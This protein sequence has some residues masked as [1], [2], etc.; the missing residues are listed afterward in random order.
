MRDFSEAFDARFGAVQRV[1]SMSAETAW[2]PLGETSL[3]VLGPTGG[4]GPV[5]NFLDNRGPGLFAVTL[6][7]PDLAAEVRAL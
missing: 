4:E 6:R 1:E 5:G 7:V 3:Q 2:A